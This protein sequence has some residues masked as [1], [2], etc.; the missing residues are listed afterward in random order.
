MRNYLKVGHE[1]WD[2]LSKYSI[3]LRL[4]MHKSQNTNLEIR[5]YVCQYNKTEIRKY[6]ETEQIPLLGQ[7]V[8]LSSLVL[9][10]FSIGTVNRDGKLIRSRIY[11]YVFKGTWAC[12]WS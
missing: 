11:Y 5:L 9:N 8:I 6:L 1:M 3:F 12:P 2:S 4:K 10:N 7:I